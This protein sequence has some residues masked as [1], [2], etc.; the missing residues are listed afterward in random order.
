[1]RP[2]W[3]PRPPE[4]CCRDAGGLALSLGFL[5]RLFN[6]SMVSRSTSMVSTAEGGLVG[7]E[8]HGVLGS[9]SWSRSRETHLRGGGSRTAQVMRC[10]VNPAILLRRRLEGMGRHP[11]RCACWWQSRRLPRSRSISMEQRPDDRDR[12]A[13]GG[14]AG[15]GTIGEIVGVVN[16]LAEESKKPCQRRA[17]RAEARWSRGR[18]L[19]MSSPRGAGLLKLPKLDRSGLVSAASLRVD[20]FR[21]GVEDALVGETP[22]VAEKPASGATTDAPSARRTPRR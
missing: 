14:Q 12:R 6:M 18:G 16:D 19:R 7:H 20:A 4:R 1:M 3:K 21:P 9:S 17:T 10:V 11:P 8:V 5:L 22:R 13:G 2:P 15:L